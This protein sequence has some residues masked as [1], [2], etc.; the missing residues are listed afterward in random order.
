MHITPLLDAALPGF[1]LGAAVTTAS[2]KPTKPCTHRAYI[3]VGEHG[4]NKQVNSVLG[5]DKS[6]A[7]VIH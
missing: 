6:F 5:G 2:T 7:W 1:F 4:Q 3:P